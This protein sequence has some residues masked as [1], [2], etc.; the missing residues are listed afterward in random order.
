ML[1]N[2]T[3]M[4]IAQCP[5]DSYN[6]ENTCVFVLGVL[7]HISSVESFHQWMRVFS[8]LWVQ[9]TMPTQ[10]RSLQT[11]PTNRNARELWWWASSWGVGMVTRRN[12]W[13]YISTFVHQGQQCSQ[14]VVGA[15]K[16]NYWQNIE[17]STVTWHVGDWYTH[18]E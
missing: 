5:I 1:F 8:E 12:L 15:V 6:Q 11:P 9:G 3:R 7:P 4:L 13:F 16:N 18:L 10:I 17:I 14:I 2:G